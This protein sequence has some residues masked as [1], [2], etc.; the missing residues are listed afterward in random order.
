MTHHLRRTL[1]VDRF[2][3]TLVTAV[4]LLLLLSALSSRRITWRGIDYVLK[5]PQNIRASRP[6]TRPASDDTAAA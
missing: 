3:T 6:A 5:G 4:N 2:G 1:A